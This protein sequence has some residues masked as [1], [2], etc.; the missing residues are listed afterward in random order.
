MTFRAVVT[1]SSALIRDSSSNVETTS[2]E[3]GILIGYGTTVDVNG[4]SDCSSFIVLGANTAILNGGDAGTFSASIF[5]G[6]Y[7]GTGDE[8]TGDCSDMVV[9]GTE[10]AYTGSCFG[11]VSV[12]TANVITDAANAFAFGGNNTVSADTAGIIG[13]N[14]T[15]TVPSTIQFGVS[16]TDFESGIETFRTLDPAVGGHTFLLLESTSADTT[17]ALTIDVLLGGYVQLTGTGAVAATIDTG[18]NFNAVDQLAGNLYNGLSF[19]CV[20]ASASGTTVTLAGS[21]GTTLLGTAAGAAGASR[22]VRFYR[23]GTATWD[24]VAV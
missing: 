3:D 14:L 11:S 15:N 13:R 4:P 19:D 16:S 7:T 5:I 12:G 2:A 9:V 23:T 6:S 8:G 21:T 1:L 22:F 24:C 20:I 10:C 18:A 17:V